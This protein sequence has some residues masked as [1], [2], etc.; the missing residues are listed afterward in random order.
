MTDRRR[1]HARLLRRAWTTTACVDRATA[2]ARGRCA[3]RPDWWAPT[4]FMRLKSGRLWYVQAAARRRAVPTCWPASDQLH[5][6]RDVHADHRAGRSATRCSGTRQEIAQRWARR[7]ASRWR[8]TTGTSLPQVAQYLSVKSGRQFLPGRAGA[9]TCAGRWSSGTATRELAPRRPVIHRDL[10]RGAHATV[11]R[12][13]TR[14][15]GPVEPYSVLA[16]LAASRCTHHPAVA[17]CCGRALTDAG[18]K[19]EVE[20]CRWND[21]DGP[22]RSRVFE[23]RAAAIGRRRQR[24]LVYHLFGTLREP[25]SLVLTED[26][27]FDFLIGV[28]RDQ[29]AHPRRRSSAGSPSRP[30]LFVGFRLDEWDF[31]VLFRSL[32]NQEGRPA[33]AV[34]ARRRA[35]RSRGGRTIDADRARALPGEYFQEHDITIYWGSTDDF[36]KELHGRGWR[37]D[38]DRRRPPAVARNPYV[39]PRPFRAARPLYGRDRRV[40]RPARPRSS[41]SGSCC[42]TRRRAPARPRSSR[43]R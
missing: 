4:L 9:A 33:A 29:D 20:V 1:V 21:D 35:D 39:G 5:R 19:P 12:S 26:D 34:H 30:L 25:R 10:G 16:E 14:D 28:T 37:G 42:C 8:R 22:G 2:V 31:R 17:A 7:T 43:P 38:R 36:V 40:Q 13:A 41:P 23:R 24:P 27:Y 3:D 15:A 32:M 11:W 18:R 6:A